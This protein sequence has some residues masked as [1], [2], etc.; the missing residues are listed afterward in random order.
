MPREIRCPVGG[1]VTL[2]VTIEPTNTADPSGTIG[3][4]LGNGL[5]N[6]YSP[7]QIRVVPPENAPAFAGAF[8]RDVYPAG[9]VM[10]AAHVMLPLAVMCA[11]GT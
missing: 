10:C 11:C 9:Q 7:V 8:F 2:T 5:Q 3:K 4:W 1:M 6:R